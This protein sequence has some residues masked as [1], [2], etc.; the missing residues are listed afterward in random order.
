MKATV[1]RRRSARKRARIPIMLE[2]KAAKL[3]AYT[4]VISRNGALVLSTKDL[5][6]KTALRL[7]N[8]RTGRSA[9]CKVVWRGG[10]ARGG[11]Q[12]GVEF[13]RGL[14]AFWGRAN[15]AAMRKNAKEK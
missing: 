15:T 2:V 5:P 8:L 13:P 7:H 10:K 6:L 14:P 9:K 1:Y 3:E 4:G 12:L 11:H